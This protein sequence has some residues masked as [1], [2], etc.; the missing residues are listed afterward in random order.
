MGDFRR[1]ACRRHVRGEPPRRDLGRSR[2]KGASLF[3]MIPLERWNVEREGQDSVFKDYVG[4]QPLV[5]L[6]GH[7]ERRGNAAASSRVPR[8]TRRLKAGTHSWVTLCWIRWRLDSSI[9]F[10]EAVERQIQQHR[11]KMVLRSVEVSLKLHKLMRW[12]RVIML[13]RTQ[14]NASHLDRC[15]ERRSVSRRGPT[16]CIDMIV[17]LVSAY[18]ILE[19]RPLR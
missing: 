10:L 12:M 4:R 18:T 7:L 9:L 13:A 6:I 1:K 17:V 15:T 14:S 16:F 19:D 3:T 11:P 8:S 2:E 5:L